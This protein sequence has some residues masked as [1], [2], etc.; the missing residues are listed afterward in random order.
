MLG[1]RSSVVAFAKTMS[2]SE[3]QTVSRTVAVEKTKVIKQELN[4]QTVPKDTELIDSTPFRSQ[5]PFT[6]RHYNSTK[7]F[8]IAKRARFVAI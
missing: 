2:M 5:P 3:T 1:T 8:E 6:N 7:C 4:Q